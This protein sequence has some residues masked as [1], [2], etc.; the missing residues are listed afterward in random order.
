MRSRKKTFEKEKKN[1]LIK[2]S[3]ARNKKLENFAMN[4]NPISSNVND[5]RRLASAK[6]GRLRL[7]GKG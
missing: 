2:G 1:F 7:N 5:A 6:E 4:V 3:R